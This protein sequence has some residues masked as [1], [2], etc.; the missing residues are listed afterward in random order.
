MNRKY[1]VDRI[2]NTVEWCAEVG[3]QPYLSFIIG[4]PWET[5]EDVHKT[6]KLVEAMPIKHVRIGPLQVFAGTPMWNNPEVYGLKFQRDR[7]SDVD[8]TN[9]VYVDNG[10]IPPS[11]LASLS[12]QA[13]RL[14]QS[15]I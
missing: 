10:I 2:K 12:A 11:R 4:L 3:I 9:N 7:L 5:E 6:F 8:V 13:R 15:K 14:C 1:N